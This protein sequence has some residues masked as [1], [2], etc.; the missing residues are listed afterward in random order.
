MS[1]SSTDLGFDLAMITPES[2]LVI[3]DDDCTGNLS[4]RKGEITRRFLYF[5]PRDWGRE[6]AP[7]DRRVGNLIAI[8]EVSGIWDTNRLVGNTE[9]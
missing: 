6:F 8:T 4:I 5:V 2:V 9:L 1:N 3:L 7:Y